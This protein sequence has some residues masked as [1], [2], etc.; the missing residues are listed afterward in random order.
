VKA[1]SLFLIRQMAF[2]LASS[3]AL[4]LV[5]A[6]TAPHMHEAQGLDN[7]RS[8]FNAEMNLNFELLNGDGES[9]K[10]SDF[11]G[12]NVLVTFGF[13]H[14]P[15]VCPT[16]A[17]NIANALKHSN[18][19]AVGIFI[20]VDTERDTPKTTDD[21]ASYFGED[22][23]GLSGSHQAVS[24]A[25]NNFNVSY[26]VTKSNNN[27]SVQHSPGTFLISPSGELIEMF[28][29]NADYKAI[30]EAMQ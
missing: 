9:I 5:Q 20:S 4:G 8:D 17:L 13:T 14:C 10:R 23:I 7:F 28:A 16:V 6:Q 11:L 25:A 26:V 18:K 30:A 24:D 12:K 19:E 21:Y 3:M 1:R 22:M 27:Y 2:V 15:D 29:M